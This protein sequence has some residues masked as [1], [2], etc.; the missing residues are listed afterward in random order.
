MAQKQRIVLCVDDDADDQM[1][2]LETIKEVDSS[3][4]VATALNG[5]EAISFLKSRKHNGGLPCLVIMDINMPLMDGKQAIVKI[6]EEQDFDGIPIVLF[7]TSSSALDKAFGD[8]YNV[9]FMT[10]PINVKSFREAVVKLLSF[11]DNCGN[12]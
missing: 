11:A 7:T 12:T 10:K 8:K 6:K 4:K 1:I 5:L 2:M 3:V 9:H